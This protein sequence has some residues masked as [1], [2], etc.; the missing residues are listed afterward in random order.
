ME[1][2]HKIN[3][4]NGSYLV[5]RSGQIM[6]ESTGRILKIQKNKLGYCKVRIVANGKWVQ[7]MIHRA[8]ALTFLQLNP[9][10]NEVNHIDGNKSNNHFSNLEWCNRS[11][12]IKHAHR[13]GL[14]T[15]KGVKNPMNGK[16]QSNES[17]KIMSE[18]A[19]L[20][21]NMNSAK[22]VLDL[23]TGVFYESASEAYKSKNM[24]V[25]EK[26]FR[27][28]LNPNSSDNNKTSF[29]YC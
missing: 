23:E 24:K 2:W 26:H 9:L 14:K 16:K 12:N 6:N 19:K 5:N 7:L 8:V 25:G 13:N 21:R 28:M 27:N 11:E 18:K 17:K 20:R 3:K 29:I 10:R 4:Y 1:E 22:D 15:N